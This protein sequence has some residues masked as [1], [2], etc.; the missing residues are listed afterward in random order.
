[1]CLVYNHANSWKSLCPA[2][3]IVGVDGWDKG[4]SKAGTK[5]F[6][7]SLTRPLS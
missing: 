6:L 1:M 2:L 3:Q 4:L 7:T 5:P